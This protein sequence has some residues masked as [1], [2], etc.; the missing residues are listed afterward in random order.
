MQHRDVRIKASR[1]A[2]S[3]TDGLFRILLPIGAYEDFHVP[4]LTQP[5]GLVKPGEGLVFL[6]LHRLD[7]MKG[8]PL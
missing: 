2:A 6:T 5:H 3:K 7:L 1:K 4:Y 8:R